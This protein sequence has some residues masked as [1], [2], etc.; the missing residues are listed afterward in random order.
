[1]AEPY[2]T[3]ERPVPFVRTWAVCCPVCGYEL[4]YEPIETDAGEFEL[5][6]ANWPVCEACDVMFEPL[7]VQVMAKADEAR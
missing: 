2:E 7:P 5:D 1:M 6:P 3:K 4:E